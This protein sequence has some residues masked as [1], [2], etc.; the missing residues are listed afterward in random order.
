M[1]SKTKKTICLLIGIASILTV[2]SAVSYAYFTASGEVRKMEATIST[3]TTSARFADNDTGITGE[4]KFGESITKKFTIQNTGTAEARVKMYWKDLV[5]TYILGSLTYTL[6]QSESNEGSYTEVVGKTNVPKNEEG[7]T[8]TE[9]LAESLTIPVNKTYYYE[10]VITLNYL[11]D[12]N[13]DPDL[14]AKFSS[15]FSLT[16][17][18]GEIKKTYTSQDILAYLKQTSNG[19]KD[20]FA[21]TAIIDEGIYEMED[22]YG[23]SYYY[24]G[25]VENNYV[26][27]GKNKSGQD[28]YWRIIRVN[29]DGSLRIIY[30][31]TSA[32]A[33]GES[34]TDRL[35]LTSVAW[36]TTN[37]NDAKYVGYMYGG[38]NGEPSTNKE[39]A[40]ANETSS[41]IKTQL[42]TWYKENIVDTG[43][44]EAVSDEIFCNDRSLGASND[45]YTNLGYGLNS[46]NYAARTRI[47]SSAPGYT[48]PSPT[49]KC[50]QKNDAFTVKDK[51]KGNGMLTYPVG[52]ITVD[53]IIT[54][55]GSYIGQSI[56]L[57]SNYNFYLYKGIKYLTFS[58]ENQWSYSYIFCIGDKGYVSNATVST[59][60]SAAPVINLTPE[61]ASTLVGTGTMTDPYREA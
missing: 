3:G 20:S 27:F 30:D 34:N 41:N 2:V 44:G 5:N 10:L 32:H 14:S 24:R 43:F 36:N 21:T 11:E 15:T 25:A 61:Y 33:N 26:K 55:G 1:N 56:E 51:T 6:R 22:D 7:K 60:I 45:Q 29:G 16:D 17:E 47:S 31:G 46:T 4:L 54:A 13:Q 19:T 42:E 28:M 48:K 53:E 8:L 23:T 38:A 12:V 9:V 50:S 40:Q 18:K 37:N 52:L 59:V 35:A 49:F 57:S 58:P 39:Q